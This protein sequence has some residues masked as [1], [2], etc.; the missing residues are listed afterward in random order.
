MRAALDNATNVTD[1]TQRLF[2]IGK[3]RNDS[4]KHTLVNKSTWQLQFFLAITYAR[5]PTNSFTDGEL[6]IVLVNWIVAA[7]YAIWF[8]RFIIMNFSLFSNMFC[9]Y[10]YKF[11]SVYFWIRYFENVSWFIIE[12]P[13]KFIQV[14]V[15]LINDVV[16]FYKYIQSIFS[17]ILMSRNIFY[18]QACNA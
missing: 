7:L 9:F 3:M 16:T 6:H 18:S 8:Y 15:M 4:K 12:L 13:S 11:G 1:K 17:R 5:L 14:F 2:K 10:Y